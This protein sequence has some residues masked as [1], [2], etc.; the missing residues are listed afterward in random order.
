LS[1]EY[2]IP[3]SE[4][5]RRFTAKEVSQ[6]V[7]FELIQDEIAKEAQRVAELEAKAKGMR[8]QL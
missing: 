7:A 6:I 1:K 5:G 3:P 8:H 2:G 4:I